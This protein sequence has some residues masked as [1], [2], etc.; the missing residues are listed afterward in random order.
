M[1]YKH[2]ATRLFDQGDMMGC[3]NAYSRF[4]DLGGRHSVY[5]RL[6][7]ARSHARMNDLPAC[8]F[9][10]TK[11][12]EKGLWY[13]HGQPEL[14]ISTYEE[15]KRV[16]PD[17]SQQLTLEQA[18]QK[19]LS[20]LD[21]ALIQRIEEMRAADQTARKTPSG[22]QAIRTVDS[23][24]LIGVFSIIRSHKGFPSESVID[25]TARFGLTLLI[26]HAIRTFP[27]TFDTLS[28]VMLE[29]AHRYDVS[30]TEF[31]AMRDRHQ[32]DLDGH[33]VFG[34]VPF[35]DDSGRL[36]LANVADPGQVDELRFAIGLA[37]LA[38]HAAAR[39][40]LLPKGYQ[41]RPPPCP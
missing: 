5:D 20:G 21:T 1:H 30:P 13:G 10:L 8:L 22:D 40:A 28:Q 18:H 31:A 16:Q 7:S 19:Y 29:A 14:D 24:N 15:L 23:L 9:Q 27:F 11:G 6:R 39:K 41:R 4:D 25:P 37:P 3:L 17:P 36:S 34:E 12:V 35:R 32:Y 26:Q 2:E 33:T 38:E